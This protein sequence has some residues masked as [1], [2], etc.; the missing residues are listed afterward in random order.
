MDKKGLH[1]EK[2]ILWPNKFKVKPHDIEKLWDILLA[3]GMA[4]SII[5]F[6]NG[7]KLEITP[8]GIQMMTRYGSYKNFLASQQFGQPPGQLTIQLVNPDNGKEPPAG[9][10]LPEKTPVLPD[11]SP[12]STRSVPNKNT[13]GR[14]K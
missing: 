11:K 12:K 10:S 1:F 6:G 9:E 13:A 7:G 5:G 3:T 8:A 4:D 14:S 2:Q